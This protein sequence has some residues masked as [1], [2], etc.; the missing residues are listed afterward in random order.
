MK[1]LCWRIGVTFVIGSAAVWLPSIA[2]AAAPSPPPPLASGHAEIVAQGIID[3]PDGTFHWQ[4]ADGSLTTGAAPTAVPTA[5]TFVLGDAGVVDVAGGAPTR[6]GPG[7]AMMLPAFSEALLS[8]AEGSATYWTLS[9]ANVADTGGAGATGGSFTL[10]AGPRDVD[11][12]RDVLAT[13]EALQLPDRDVA[14]LL[15]VTSGGAVAT[16][17]DVESI[18]LGA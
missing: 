3:F 1:R 16:S 13:G 5:V 2:D 12:V 8:T 15:L 9:I 14:T 17:T 4:V 7:E 10:D 18:E 11:L 6:L